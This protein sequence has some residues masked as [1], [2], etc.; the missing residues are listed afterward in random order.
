MGKSV[1]L[2]NMKSHFTKEELAQHIDAKN[3]LY[4]YPALDDTPPEWLTGAAL[5]EWNRIT[6]YLIA[7][8]PIS[9]LDRATLADYCRIYALIQKCNQVIDERGEVLTTQS[10][11]LKMNP[12]TRLLLNATRDLGSLANDLGLN[13]QARSKLEL[14]NAKKDAPEDDF[15]ELLS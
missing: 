2:S 11:G 4:E 7:H 8:T 12:Y 14:K 9:E 15:A 1:K 13:I 6:P 5:I 10:G 3:A